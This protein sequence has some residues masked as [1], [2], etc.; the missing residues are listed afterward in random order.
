MFLH[1]QEQVDSVKSVPIECAS[2]QRSSQFGKYAKIQTGLSTN[3]EAP[4]INELKNNE[5]LRKQYLKRKAR[6]MSVYTRRIMIQVWYLE[7]SNKTG[8]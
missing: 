3:I 2:H 4:K 5:H 7:K 8:K 6:T 1:C